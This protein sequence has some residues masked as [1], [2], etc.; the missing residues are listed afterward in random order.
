MARYYVTV[1][2]DC[3][4]T[5]VV[6]VEADGPDEAE[7]NALDEAGSHP[8]RFDWVR[9]ECSEGEAYIP[10]PGNSATTEDTQ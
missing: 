1:T 8:S 10:A 2:R 4:E 5:T 7:A 6:D 9:D 3:T